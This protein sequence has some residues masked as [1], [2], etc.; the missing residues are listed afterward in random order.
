[1]SALRPPPG[2]GPEPGPGPAPAP[3]P[4]LQHAPAGGGPEEGGGRSSTRQ[5]GGVLFLLHPGPVIIVIVKRSF[6][7]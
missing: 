6:R 5:V 4:A 7:A 1:M 3:G 2:L